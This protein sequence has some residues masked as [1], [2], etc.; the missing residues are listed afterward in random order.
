MILSPAQQAFLHLSLQ[1][2]I[3]R[4]LDD[5]SHR[6]RRKLHEIE[7]QPLPDSGESVTSRHLETMKQEI[8]SISFLD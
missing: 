5:L 3:H 6:H 2:K 1:A 8:K 7:Q 4:R